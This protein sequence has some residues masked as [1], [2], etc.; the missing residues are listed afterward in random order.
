M[1]VS[2]CQNIIIYWRVTNI[3]ALA[4]IYTLS[5]IDILVII[6]VLKNLDKKIFFIEKKCLTLFYV[7][8]PLFL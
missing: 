5:I 7:V 6:D 3:N 1:E 4:K 2:L 8:S